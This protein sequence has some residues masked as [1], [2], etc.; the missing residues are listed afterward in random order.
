MAIAK[1]TLANMP[2]KKGLSTSLLFQVETVSA[3]LR[4]FWI[5]I[6]TITSIQSGGSR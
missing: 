6:L 2:P 1:M 5:I 4:N 3:E